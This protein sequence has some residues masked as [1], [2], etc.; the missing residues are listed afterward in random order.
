MP[1]SVIS[2]VKEVATIDAQTDEDLT[3]EDRSQNPFEHEDDVGPIKVDFN[4][5]LV[6]EG[7][8]NTDTGTG[9]TIPTLEMEYI[10]TPGVYNA[11]PGVEYL[12]IETPVMDNLDIDVKV[13]MPPEDTGTV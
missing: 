13:E 9:I 1:T 6:D 3:F 7:E 11:I 2:R 5:G 4:T 10:E 8:Q 12:P